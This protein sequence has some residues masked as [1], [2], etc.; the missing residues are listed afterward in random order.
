MTF[1]R[2]SYLPSTAQFET[3][4]E[5]SWP[6]NTLKSYAPTARKGYVRGASPV[7]YAPRVPT[8]LRLEVAAS[9][10]APR[11]QPAMLAAA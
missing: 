9:T 6:R 1:T 5:L 4:N 11:A 3:Y 10:V 7:S 2:P 8:L